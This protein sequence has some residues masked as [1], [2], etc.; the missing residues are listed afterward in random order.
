MA[1]GEYDVQ[2]QYSARNAIFEHCIVECDMTHQNADY[3]KIKPLHFTPTPKDKTKFNWFAFELA[4]EIEQTVPNK[5]KMYLSKHG[6]TQQIL[7]KSCIKL[8]TLLQATVLNKLSGKIP[9]M[10]ISHAQVE[11]AFPKLNDK[12]LDELLYCTSAAWEHLLDVCA[13]CPSACVSNRHDYATMF[14]DEEYSSR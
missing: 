13:I 7:N 8:A 6:Y 10:E 5:L 11:A 1:S 4:N 2:I 12:T 3:L 9:D 14:D